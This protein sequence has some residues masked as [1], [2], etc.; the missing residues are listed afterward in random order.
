MNA[1]ALVIA[2]YAPLMLVLHVFTGKILSAWRKAPDSR[3]SRWF[4]ARRI[5]RTEAL[6]WLLALASWFLWRSLALKILVVTFALIHLV[7]W[8]TDEFA[9]REAFFVPS[10]ALSRAIV[11]FDLVEAVALF[12]IGT[13]AILHL[14]HLR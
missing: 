5:L 12:G 8:G 13:V 6:F 2:I 9:R 10:S 3:I 7:L 1:L 14:S 11:V 4:T